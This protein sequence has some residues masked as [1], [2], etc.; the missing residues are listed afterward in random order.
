MIIIDIVPAL[1]RRAGAEGLRDVR[2]GLWARAARH[3]KRLH[4]LWAVPD[5]GFVIFDEGDDSA[6][7]RP[8]TLR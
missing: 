1:V 4:R 7:Y 3:N 6:L 8:A 2:A 5:R